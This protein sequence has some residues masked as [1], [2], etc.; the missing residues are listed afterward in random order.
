LIADLFALLGARES[1][2]EDGDLPEAPAAKA[3]ETV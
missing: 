2:R 3:N 1:V